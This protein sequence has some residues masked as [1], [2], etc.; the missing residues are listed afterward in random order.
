MSD[1]DRRRF[2]KGV[3]GKLA[4]A[5]GPVVLASAVVESSKVR[6]HESTGDDAPHNDIQ[7]RADRLAAANRL[8]AETEAGAFEFLNGGFRNAPLGGFRNTPLGGF[9]NRPLSSFRN[10]PLSGFRNTPLGTFANA[11]IGGFRNTPLSTFNNGGW[12]NGVWGGFNNGGWP[13]V[14]WRNW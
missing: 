8:P 7:D 12:P 1:L 6:G 11:P 2:L 13:N 10:T 4:Q 3:L 14:G 9:A 5:A